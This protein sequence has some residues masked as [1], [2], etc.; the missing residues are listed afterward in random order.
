MT[1]KRFQIFSSVIED[2]Q[3]II[4]IILCN[5]DK[6]KQKFYDG[7][8]GLNDENEQLKMENDSLKLLVQNWEL[9]DEEKDWQLDK[10]NQALKKLKKENEQLKK[11]TQQV[12]DILKEYN[13]FVS[14]ID[15]AIAIGFI[16]R[17]ARAV[18]MELEE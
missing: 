15:S 10:Q 9:L 4:P 16:E 6:Q 1:G 14:F 3:G 2:T 13:D 11:E 8:N 7:L 5:N 18:G 17:I 12:K